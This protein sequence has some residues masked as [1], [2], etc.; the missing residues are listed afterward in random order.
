VR[1]PPHRLF[2]IKAKTMSQSSETH[3]KVWDLFV[4][5]FHWAQLILFVIAYFTRN[6]SALIHQT[7][8]YLI[9]AL[10]V[11]RI[12]WGFIGSDHA[13]FKSFIY[14]PIRVFD[15]LKDTV[16]FKA[17]R[18]LGH[19]PA[20]GAMVVTLIIMLLGVCISGALLSTPYFWGS[21]IMEDMHEILTNITLALVVFHLLGVIAASLEHK[22]NL[23]K[24][25]FT[26]WKRR[27]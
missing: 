17:K 14:H 27:D 10:L 4:R 18:Y 16:T 21:E 11:M 5:C 7:A 8:G 1:N 13:Q 22:E 24:S 25:M 20:G 2:A 19:N 15:F 3:I 26:G 9:L 23:V 12:V 6:S